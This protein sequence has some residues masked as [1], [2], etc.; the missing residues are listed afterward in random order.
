MFPEFADV[1][2]SEASAAGSVNTMRRPNMTHV[3]R[4]ST[5]NVRML[6]DKISDTFEL[7]PQHKV[8]L[9]GLQDT[10]THILPDALPTLQRA[11]RQAR[12]RL[13]A[14]PIT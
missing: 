4:I 1:G 8:Y 12:W 6:R 7:L 11:C 2:D 9:G 3:L 10:H 14:N 13:V 5:L